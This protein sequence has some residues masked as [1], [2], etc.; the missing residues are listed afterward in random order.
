MSELDFTVGIDF[1]INYPAIVIKNIRENIIN[2]F[3]FF[4]NNKL[5]KKDRELITILEQVNNYKVIYLPERPDVSK[6][7]EYSEK[8]KIKS[9]DAEV[10][11]DI[12][13]KTI[14]PYLDDFNVLIS[15]EGFSFGSRGSSAIELIGYQYVLRSK[16]MK[17]DWVFE[18]NSPMSIK[19]TAGKGNL[20]KTGMIDSYIN[21]NTNDKDLNNC[22]LRKHIIKNR[23]IFR[24][25]TKWSKIIEDIIDGFWALKHQEEK[26]NKK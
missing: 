23:E 17:E 24:N 2:Y 12:I 21:N 26:I 9:K 16:F 11:T 13:I 1:S 18:V 19:K 15:I 22:N 8:E 3:A 14:K 4:R 20:D 6:K 5:T 25:R 7:I 10:L